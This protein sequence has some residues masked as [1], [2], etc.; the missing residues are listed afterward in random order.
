M[1][2]IKVDT[3]AEKTSANGVTVDGLNIKDSKL[4]TA[5]SVVTSN[6]TDGNITTAKILDDN[7]TYAKIQNVS[8]TDRI[9]GRDSSGAG[10]I[11]EITPANLRTMLNV[12]DGANVGGGK[13]NQATFSDQTIQFNTN[14]GSY[15]DTGIKVAIT[16]SASNSK[17]AVW[18]AGQFNKRTGSGNA[19]A[20]LYR[21]SQQVVGG[22]G[23]IQFDG[24]G[25]NS[26]L[27]PA[28]FSY[29]DSPNTTS[30]V[31]YKLFLKVESAGDVAHSAYDPNSHSSFLAMEVLA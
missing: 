24:H 5:N 15:V 3:V 27:I 4:V 1:S 16:P 10:V 2:E 13:I 21:G 23:L 20:T 9:L 8:A 25:S 30:E 11:E 12:A 29:L 7:V 19:M 28:G 17:V 31:E 18:F 6:V 22:R 26:T 14:S